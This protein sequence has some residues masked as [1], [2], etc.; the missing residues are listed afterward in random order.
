MRPPKEAAS[1]SRL[2]CFVSTGPSLA[3][4]TTLADLFTL[5]LFAD[6]S[7]AI[8]ASLRSW[9]NDE[10]DDGLAYGRQARLGRRRVDSFFPPRLCG[11]AMLG[12]CVGHHSPESVT[13]KAMPA[14]SL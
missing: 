13:M 3:I 11:S 1:Q 10:F 2:A 5:L 9:S 8:R 7:S 14:T 12:G 6:L 4:S